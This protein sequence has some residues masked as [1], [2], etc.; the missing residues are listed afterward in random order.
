MSDAA[1]PASPRTPTADY[2]VVGVILTAVTA[3]LVSVTG[4]APVAEEPNA[5]LGPVFALVGVTTLVWFTMLVVRNASVMRGI[6]SVRYYESYQ[7]DVPP[8]WIERPA[9][10]F[11]NLMQ[12]PTLFYVLCSL[13]I[14]THKVDHAQVVLAWI[15][16]I[17]RAVHA[18][19]YI[20][21]NRV[22]LRFAAYVAGCLALGVMW[23]R[24]G[25]QV[26]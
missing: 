9:R 21:V 13:M 20:L 3:L 4:S 14:A 18:A 24:F 23:T 15:F 26:Q 19:I 7:S 8:D 16:V 5:L 11:N 6:A 1:S 12:I 22:S 10:T 17:T 2:V 25:I